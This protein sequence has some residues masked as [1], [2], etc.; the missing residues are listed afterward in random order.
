MEPRT[1]LCRLLLLFWSLYFTLVTASNLV[2]GFQ[3]LGIAPRGWTFTSGNCALIAETVATYGLSS[4]FA[5]F[6]FVCV[7]LIELA[8]T[9]LFW[10][11]LRDSWR[12]AEN[13]SSKIIRALVPAVGLFAGFIVSDELFIV[14]HRTPGLETGHFLVLCALLVSWLVIDSSWRIKG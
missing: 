2:D 10:I 7:I 6:L 1:I 13:S 9:L 11:A 4:G 5:A 3:A 12:A 8:V 14:Y